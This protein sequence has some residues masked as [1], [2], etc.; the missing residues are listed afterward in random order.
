MQ[1]R[2]GWRAYPIVLTARP[3]TLVPL[4]PQHSETCL[5]ELV[6]AFE[7]PSEEARILVGILSTATADSL[8]A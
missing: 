2:V 4:T 7:K 1:H 6:W 5:P 8:E 3:S